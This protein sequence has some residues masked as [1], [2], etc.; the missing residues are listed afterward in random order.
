MRLHILPLSQFVWRGVSRNGTVLPSRRKPFRAFALGLVLL[1]AM[2]LDNQAATL[3]WT[4]TA[5]DGKVPTAN[6]WSPSQAP[7]TGDLLIFSGSTSLTPQ[8]A[9]N[10]TLG[11]IS[12]ASGAS[13]FTLGGVGTYT[14][15][16]SAGVTNNSTNTQIIGNNVTLGAAQTWNATNGNLSFSGTITDGGFDLTIAGTSNTAI[17]G[18]VAGT[19][20]LTKNGSGILTLSGG[21]NNTYSGVTTVNDGELDLNKTATKNAFAGNLTVGDSTG[22]SSSAIVKLLAANQIP[23]V[24]ISI[25]NDGLFNLNNNSDTVGALAMTSGN[26]STGTGTL[27]LGGDV[28]TNADSTSAVISGNLG[29]GGNRN[30]TVADGAAATDLNVTAVVSGAFTVTKSGAGTMVL[31]G[32]NTYTKATA[33]NAGALFVNGS[34][35]SG[36]AFTV[37]NSGTVLGGSG[38]IGGSVTLASGTH[39]EPGASGIGSTAILHTGALTMQSGSIFN[40]D[41]NTAAA[42]TGFDQVSVTGT[43]N[44]TGSILTVN[45][46]AGLHVGD[47]LAIVL[48]DSSDAITGT[49]SGLAQGSSF[50]SG[51]WSFSIDYAANGGDGTANDIVL[52]VTAVPEPSTYVTG[53][54]SLGAVAVFQRRWLWRRRSKADSVDLRQV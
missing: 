20:G 47:K 38:T 50:S 6:N 52:T 7:T 10:L 54:L 34:T 53:L 23:A 8:M 45:P 3:T 41:L 35:V 36:S 40:V 49:F 33:V 11:S 46:S 16:T 22:A 44:V 24:A 25:N 51:A 15:N 27:T 48:N 12:F 31:A 32:T 21:A 17:S 13:A 1:V 37:N 9:P 5:G 29:L 18:V 28:T 42:G 19:G 26:V 30:F 2:V 43:V 4:G 14:I 39:L